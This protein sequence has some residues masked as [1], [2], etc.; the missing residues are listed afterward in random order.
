MIDVILQSMHLPEYPGREKALEILSELEYGHAPETPARIWTETVSERDASGGKA[1]QTRYALW[2]ETESGDQAS[3]PFVLT[4]PKGVKRPLTIIL[5]DFEETIPNRCYPA[6][7]LSDMGIAVAQLPYAPV[8][9]DRDDGFAD[10]VCRALRKGPQPDNGW[11]KIALWAWAASRVADVLC[12]R[13]DLDTE[14]LAVAGHSRLGKTALWAAA[15]DERFTFVLVNDSGCSGVSLARNN[16][17]E[18]VEAI[19]K[20][21]PHWFCPN[22]GQFAGR[23]DEMPF[24]QHFLLCAAAPRYVFVT[25]AEDDLWSC[26]DNAYFSCKAAD[27]LK[28]PDRMPEPGEVFPEGRI[29]YAIRPG[30][31][32]LSRWD[33]HQFILFIQLHKKN[34]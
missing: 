30:G 23:E 26:P 24:D 21:F 13:D 19:S 18:T 17:G 1:L 2:F 33:W 25:S 5:I 32:H 22:Y 14:N 15:L 16:T 3:F 4:V 31:H 28:S 7:E 8:A 34:G 6:E 11:G 29:G 12:A 20:A 9:C 27:G 10:P